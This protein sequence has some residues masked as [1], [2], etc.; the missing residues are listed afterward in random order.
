MK[1]EFEIEGKKYEIPTI[2]IRDYYA[3]RTELAVK[4]KE[5]EFEIIAQ[6]TGCPVNHLRSLKLD[7]WQSLSFHVNYLIDK[8]INLEPELI[9]QFT[10]EGIEY[11]LV[12]FDTMTIGEF[13]DI[14]VIINSPNADSKLHEMLAILYRPIVKKK[15]KK[16]I[17]EEH[18]YEGYKHRCEIFLDLSIS[19]ARSVSGFFFHTGKAFL[20]PIKDFS[21]LELNQAMEK[22]Q[23]ITSTLLGSGTSLSSDS[24]TEMSLILEELKSLELEKHLT[25]S[26]GNLT[27]TKS[28]KW[29]LKNWFK[30]IIK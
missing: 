21:N 16:N 3:M 27:K 4:G 7:Q 26:P 30:N 17:I 13:A 24:L 9:H 25:S 22:I 8:E 1:I 11:G 10:H 19:M 18:D 6:L 12:D 28:K 2:R 23:K 20:N 5:A 15:W 14:D 29:N